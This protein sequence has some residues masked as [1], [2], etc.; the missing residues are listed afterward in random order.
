MLTI[1]RAVFPVL[2]VLAVLAGTWSRTGGSVRAAIVAGIAAAVF[3]TAAV[4]VEKRL[5]RSIRPYLVPIVYGALAGWATGFVVRSA[6][7]ILPVPRALAEPFHLAVLTLALVCLGI[8]L[9]VRAAATGHVL[10]FRK[11]ALPAPADPAATRALW[12]AWLGLWLFLAAAGGYYRLSPPNEV[13]SPRSFF[14]AL[15]VLAAVPVVVHFAGACKPGLPAAAL[16]ALFFGAAM[17]AE[18]FTIL[19]IGTLLNF[20]MRLEC[21]QAA[22]FIFWSYIG[23]AFMVQGK[24]EC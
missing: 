7:L 1:I 23:L 10:E 4:V 22:M 8:A 16:T 18:T 14:A 3:A 9:M 6:L 12:C 13:Y 11:P 5:A 17:A 21:Q 2:F 24:R 20:S 19:S 15:A